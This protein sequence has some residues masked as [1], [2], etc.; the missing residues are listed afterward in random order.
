MLPWGLIATEG[1]WRFAIDFV[2]DFV[3]ANSFW[4]G[5]WLRVRC[6]GGSVL[7]LLWFLWKDCWVCGWLLGVP[8]ARTSIAFAISDFYSL[9]VRTCSCSAMIA[10]FL[11]FSFSISSKFLL[12]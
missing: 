7:S 1:D 2:I 11:S 5:T 12:F 3:A 4:L 8:V 9:S 10:W 6:C